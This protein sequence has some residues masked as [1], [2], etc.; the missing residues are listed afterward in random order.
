M[1]LEGFKLMIMGMGTVFLFLT[2]MV[3]CLRSVAW[4]SHHKTKR[5]EKL[6][7]MEKQKKSETIVSPQDEVPIAVFAAAIN[8]FESD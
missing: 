6:M 5:E 7:K 1:L 2:V 4:I 8:A 3:Y